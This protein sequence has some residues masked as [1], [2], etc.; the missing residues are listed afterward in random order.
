MDIAVGQTVE[1][2]DRDGRRKAAVVLATP[3]SFGDEFDA[4]SGERAPEEGKVHLKVFSYTGRDYVKHNI[5][6]GEGPY[7]YTLR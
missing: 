3:E 1:Y 2:R 7:T 4:R 5:A 6:A